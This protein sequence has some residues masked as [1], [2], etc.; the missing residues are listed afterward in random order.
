MQECEDVGDGKGRKGQK[1][2]GVSL[3][4]EWVAEKRV[5]DV[6]ELARV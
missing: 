6:N 4:R 1:I 5:A 3:S 2:E